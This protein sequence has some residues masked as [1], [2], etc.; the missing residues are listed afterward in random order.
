MSTGEGIYVIITLTQMPFVVVHY[1]RWAYRRVA[2]AQAQVERLKEIGR[3]RDDQL[4]R[5]RRAY[6][7]AMNDRRHVKNRLKHAQ[8]ELDMLREVEFRRSRL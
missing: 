4:Q 7:A 8:E 3:D 1:M 2:V 5:S 6:Q